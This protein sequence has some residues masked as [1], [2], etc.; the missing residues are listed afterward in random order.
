MFGTENVYV[1]PGAIVGFGSIVAF[2]VKVTVL[3]PIVAIIFFIFIMLPVVSP[4]ANLNTPLLVH[5]AL[6][7][8]AD[9]KPVIVA[10]I[11]EEGLKIPIL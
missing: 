6:L 1:L 8:G 5:I 4:T 7:T 11:E 3:L 2:G 9:A 10:E